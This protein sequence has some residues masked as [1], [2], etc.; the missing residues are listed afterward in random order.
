MIILFKNIKDYLVNRNKLGWEWCKKFAV[1]NLSGLFLSGV[2]QKSNAD[3][4]AIRLD[5]SR[6]DLNSSRNGGNAVGSKQSDV[7]GKHIH[8]YN[9]EFTEAQA[10][11]GGLVG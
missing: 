2:S 8:V 11:G 6:P 1:P 3:P 5:K 4:D 7:V 9:A 10:G